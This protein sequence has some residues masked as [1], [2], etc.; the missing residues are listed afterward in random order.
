V[1]LDGPARGE[2]IGMARAPAY[3][4]VGAR[5]T[6]P[7]VQELLR[8]A[9]AYLAG[10]GWMCRSGGAPGAATACEAGALQGLRAGAP[11]GLTVYLPWPTFERGQRA[12][13]ALGARGEGLRVAVLGEP[14][15]AA[16]AL[17]ARHLPD[18]TRLA[19]DDRALHARTVHLILG[20]GL[21]APAAFVLCWTADGALG[22]RAAP[23][24]DATGD[25]GPALRLAAARGIPVLNV[26]RPD[27]LARVERRL[28]GA[29]TAAPAPPAQRTGGAR[30]RPAAGP[31]G[32][33]R[34]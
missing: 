34:W 13:R 24:T 4:G 28:A 5:Q 18:W 10:L 17:A 16:F 20:P 9:A 1:P 11:G 7:D 3:A 26:A 19:L 2:W 14:R 30:P 6:P 22:T 29:P 8:R 27:H 32:V 21:A 33:G 23:V 15:P 31:S 12:Y 25:S